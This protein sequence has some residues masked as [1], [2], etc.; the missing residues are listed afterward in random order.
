M[1]GCV[2]S[3]SR[4]DSRRVPPT[5]PSIYYLYS[6][7]QRMQILRAHFRACCQFEFDKD[8]YVQE[9]VTAQFAGVETHV[10]II[11]LLRRIQSFFESLA[12]EDE[13]DYWTTSD[14]VTLA[15]HIRSPRRAPLQHFELLMRPAKSRRRKF[16]PLPETGAA[17]THFEHRCDLLG[18]NA[19]TGL[20]FTP[21]RIIKLFAAPG[22]A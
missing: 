10:A 16:R 2:V 15:D 19:L 4:V 7:E 22:V 13:G 17:A 11:D 20:S 1:N 3:R 9:Y 5:I 12:V 18:K 6:L 14:E 8:C 21:T